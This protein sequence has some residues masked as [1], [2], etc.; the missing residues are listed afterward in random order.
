M[1]KQTESKVTSKCP[2]RQKEIVF[3]RRY[4]LELPECILVSNKSVNPKTCLMKEVCGKE[5]ETEEKA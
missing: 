4:L 5:L 3:Y 2:L 1:R